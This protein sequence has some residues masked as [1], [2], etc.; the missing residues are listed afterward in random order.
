MMDVGI[1]EE[2]VHRDG[3][4]AFGR[5]PAED[6]RHGTMLNVA[7]P[8]ARRGLHA[9]VRHRRARIAGAALLGSVAACGVWE[10]TAL[11]PDVRID[12]VRVTAANL[13][14]LVRNHGRWPVRFTGCD[15]PVAAEVLRLVDG[16]WKQAVGD[17][18]VCL[19]ILGPSSLVLG[20]GDSVR[21]A[22][23]HVGTGIYRCRVSYTAPNGERYAAASRTFRVE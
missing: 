22:A 2:Q 7:G 9:R 13:S 15:R 18:H 16:K 23:R 19:A 10:P 8:Q 21:V 4:P 3:G 11:R 17:G 14:V 12:D 6:S 1:Q 5:Y 20:P